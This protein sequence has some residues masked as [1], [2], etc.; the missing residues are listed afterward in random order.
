MSLLVRAAG[1]FR[2]RMRHVACK[3][4]CQHADA[5]L[6]A[7]VC[8]G[9]KDAVAARATLSSNVGDPLTIVTSDADV[10]K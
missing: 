1:C 10:P 2:E 4:P 9:V 3:V 6:L 5:S 7:T 8:A